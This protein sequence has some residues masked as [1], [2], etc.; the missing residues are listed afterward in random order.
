[1]VDF[2]SLFQGLKHRLATDK[3]YLYLLIGFLAFLFIFALYFL[4]FKKPQ[5]K[6]TLPPGFLSSGLIAYWPMESL[7]G[8]WVRDYTQNNNHLIIRGTPGLEAKGKVGS[9]LRFDGRDSFLQLIFNPS[10]NLKTD[11]S[12]EGWFK[13]EGAAEQNLSPFGLKG[14]QYKKLLVINNPNYTELKDFQVRIRINTK[15]LIS[16]GRM[17]ED[18]KDVRF[19]DSDELTLLDFWLEK[20]C[21]TESTLFWVKIPYLPPNS[22]KNVFIYYGN[23]KEEESLSSYQKAMEYPPIQWWKKRLSIA[24]AVGI[25]KTRN[26]FLVLEK[27]LNSS[28]SWK[29]EVINS[30]GETWRFPYRPEVYRGAILD[31]Y[32]LGDAVLIGGYQE[33]GGDREWRAEIVNADGRISWWFNKNYSSGPDEITAVAVDRENNIILAGYDSVP[34]DPQWRVIKVSPQG[35]I[36]WEYKLNPSSGSDAITDVAVDSKNFIIISGYDKALGH[37]RWR[38][39]KLSPEGELVFSYRLDIS[40]FSDVPLALALD[41][42]DNIIVGGYDYFLKNGSWRIIK[43]SPDGKRVWQWYKNFS[44]GDDEVRSVVVDDKDN[45]IVGGVTFEGGRLTSKVIKFNPQGNKIWE[46]NVEGLDS[47]NLRDLA[48]DRDGGILILADSLEGGTIEVVKIGERKPVEREPLVVETEDFLVKPLGENSIIQKP[49]SFRVS[50]ALDKMAG[51]IGFNAIAYNIE[52]LNWYHFALTYDGKR[53]NL[54][55]NGKLVNTRRVVGNIPQ[56]RNNI[57]VGYNFRGLIDELK[58]YNRALSPAEVKALYNWSW[59]R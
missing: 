22:K 50:A 55:L 30:Q 7:K 9:A 33:R 32:S 34:G 46:L 43:L 24:E 45:I 23:S 42:N 20:G 53:L 47:A 21:N 12:I 54:Y 2:N 36:M 10:F 11:L 15:A 26:I 27:S 3:I 18:C 19:T 41:S 1:M 37:D 6:V 31:G 39:E 57:Y 14:Y 29:I 8:N 16:T 35:K 28:S 49:G 58:V 56:N 5:P 48:I 38:I 51:F 59:K 44:S 52:P 40:D 17:R 13:V 4:F 25:H